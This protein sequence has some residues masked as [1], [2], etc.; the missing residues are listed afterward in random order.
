M[1]FETLQA[2][3]PDGIL[4]LMAEFHA[5]PDP[6]KVD[7]TVGVYKNDDGVTP[8]MAAVHEAEG[9]LHDTEGT[10]VYLPPAGAPG[11][12]E[13]IRDLVLGDVVATVGDRTAVI[14]TPGGCGALRVGAELYRR[15]DAGRTVYVST[16]TWGNHAAL[17]EGAGLTVAHYPYYLPGAHALET[18]AML[19]ALDAA[20][21]GSLVLLQASCHNPTGADPDAAARTAILDRLETRGLVPFFDMA[22]QGLGDGPDADAAFLREAAARLPELLIAVSCSKNFGLYRERTGALLAIGAAPATRGA[23][24]SH[25]N[26]VARAM[27]S[28]SPAHGALLVETVLGTPDLAARWREELAAMAARIAGLRAGLASALAERR[29]ELDFT[30][31]TRQK[32][33]FSLLGLEPDAVAALRR[34]RHLY[35]VGDSRINLAGLNAENLP[36]VAEALAPLMR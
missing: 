31:L 10:K 29:P 36:R 30:W 17:L 8:I 16:P 34:D 5:D 26:Q 3:P 35:M 7:L 33:M 9:R 28:M 13:R 32:G 22:Y 2:V 25:A 14:Q 20:P 19:G 12:R 6:A 24:E 4:G 11:F 23:L 1:T 27:Y 15:A 21:A 18:D